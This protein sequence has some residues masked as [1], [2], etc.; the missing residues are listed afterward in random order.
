MERLSPKEVECKCGNK[1]VLDRRRDWCTKCGQ[2]LYYN[3]KDQ[4]KHTYNYYYTLT[5][6]LFFFSL[7][8]YFFIEMVM[9]LWNY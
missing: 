8:T 1:M 9:P 6:M 7:V 3:P 4:K 2:A 5:L